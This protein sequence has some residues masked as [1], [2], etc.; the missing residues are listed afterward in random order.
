MKHSNTI[1]ALLL[2]AGLLL[3]AC[4]PAAQPPSTDSTP[5]N[6]EVAQ[7]PTE[8][9]EYVDWGFS[10]DLQVPFRTHLADPF[11]Q[12]YPNVSVTLLGGITEDAIAQIR[13]SR[14]DSPID[15]IM[16]GEMRYIDAAQ[17]GILAPLTVNEVPNLANV[18]KEFQEPCEGYGAAWMVQL[19]GVAY[20]TDLVSK[21]EKWTDLWNEEY[22]G[23]IGIPSPS[24][25][26]GFLFLVLVAKQFGGDENNLEV[27]FEKLDELAPFVVAA[28]PGQLAQLLESG[29]ISLAVNWQTQSGPSVTRNPKLDFTIPEPGG[30]GVISCYTVL[31][32]SANKEHAYNYINDALSTD[33]QTKISAPPWYFGPTNMDVTIDPGSAKFLPSKEALSD[34]LLVDWKI[35]NLVRSDITDQ[36]IRRYGQ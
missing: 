22:K 23:K 15:S 3:G 19:I 25:N 10:G 34:L 9:V 5:A 20:N 33:F 13:A 6:T 30:A 14:G 4:A 11:E 2:T 27:A 12:K 17:E 36:F 26:N 32:G 24:A 7:A 18:N 1:L 16:M 31:E 8:R 28:N 35:A 29:E 21:P